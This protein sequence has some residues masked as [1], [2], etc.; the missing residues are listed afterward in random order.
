MQWNDFNFRSKEK[1]QNSMTVTVDTYTTTL[2]LSQSA[3]PVKGPFCSRVRP[4][5]V[6]IWH[7]AASSMRAYSTVRPTSANT[8]ILHVTG[9]DKRAFRVLTVKR[10]TTTRCVS[11]LANK[12]LEL[13]TWRGN[14]SL[15]VEIERKMRR[16]KTRRFISYLSYFDVDCNM[17]TDIFSTSTEKFF[18]G[19]EAFIRI[20]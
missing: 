9:T 8:R 5:T 3:S 17:T 18:T 11:T 14:S 1:I 6:S 12:A 19:R 4:C 7:P 20:L 13:E 10:K 2:I 15:N 16:H